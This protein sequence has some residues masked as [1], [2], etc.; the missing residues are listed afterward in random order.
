M[1]IKTMVGISVGAAALTAG[2]VFSLWKIYK[3]SEQIKE[4][5]NS[6]DEVTRNI[7]VDIPDKVVAVAMDRAANREAEAA[8]KNV[9]KTATDTIQKSVDKAIEKEKSGIEPAV[10]MELE[11][12]I[13]LVDI[14][15]IKSKVA[16]E[17][18]ST[19][20]SGMISRISG[21]SSSCD[22]AEVIR[23]C[24]EAGMSGWQIQDVIETMKKEG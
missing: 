22:T 1:E 9:A 17:A 20:T 12:K 5:N 6:V 7:N 16:K 23:A 21:I 3:L 18:A 14:E 11:K 13:S 2:N 4:F 8:A 24:K 15:D 10:R 19:I